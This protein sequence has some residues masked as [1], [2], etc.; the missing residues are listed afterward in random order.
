MIDDDECG[1]VVEGEL[2]GETEV[3]RK[4]LPQWHFAHHKSRMT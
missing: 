2:E 3:L 4:I 1:E